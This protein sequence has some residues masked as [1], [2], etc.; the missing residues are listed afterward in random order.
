MFLVLKNELARH[1]RFHLKTSVSG[2]CQIFSAGH[3]V[4]R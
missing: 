2:H 3:S 1:A 4:T